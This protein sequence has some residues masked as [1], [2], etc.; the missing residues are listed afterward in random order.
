MLSDDAAVNNLIGIE[1][2]PKDIVA[3]W[4]AR[5]AMWD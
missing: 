4:I 1:T 3:D 2:S 5:A